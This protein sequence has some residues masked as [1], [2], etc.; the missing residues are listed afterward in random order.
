MGEKAERVFIKIFLALSVLLFFILTLFSFVISWVNTELHEEH[1]HWVK[2]S[3][4]CNLVGLT[5]VC[6]VILLIKKNA[7]RF[8]KI[9]MK[10]VAV[11][12]SVIASL[13]S[14]WWIVAVNV[15]PVDDQRKVCMAASQ[16][17][18]GIYIMF[19]KGGYLAECPHQLGLV[20]LLRLLFK[21]FGD[22]NYR[23]FQ[24][25][26]AI[27]LGFIIYSSYK[28]TAIISKSEVAGLVTLVLMMLCLPLFLY[29][30]YVYGEIL[31]IAFIL[32]AF[33]LLLK[34]IMET[35]Q[36][37]YILYGI[38]IFGAVMVR[39]NSLVPIIAMIVVILIR[40]LVERKIKY[41]ILLLVTIMSM[42]LQS[43]IMHQIYDK[44][45]YDDAKAIPSILWVSM[46]TNDEWRHA[47]WYDGSVYRVFEENDC[48][49]VIASEKA[50]E[51]LKAFIGFCQAYPKDGINF[52]MR[53][54]TAQWIAPM[55]QSIVMNHNI[56]GQQNKF[57]EWIYSPEHS[58]KYLDAWMNIH[59]LTVFLMILIWLIKRWKEPGYIQDYLLLIAVFGG[60][61]FSIIWEAKSRYVFPY[62]VM[63]IPMAAVAI[64]SIF[65]KEKVGC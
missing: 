60:F 15:S 27:A 10:K 24:V 1:L 9:N 11:I 23:V 12:V 20:T 8:T 49:P 37:Q 35:G 63:M 61:L 59:Q 55:Y 33:L 17:N 18:S 48:N 34:S 42:F 28:I 32:C 41:I 51:I 4:L 29:V 57:A 30:P 26:S 5:I 54:I 40:L 7:K 50:K 14:I 56:E 46:G 45:L 38:M 58:W 6:V 13:I 31:S 25:L 44:Y 19:E 62:Y 3:I 16:I 65:S 36:K 64:E 47:G 21:I 22:G 53:K 39:K 43:F 52:Y 2:D